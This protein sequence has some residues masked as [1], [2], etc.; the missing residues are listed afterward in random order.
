MLN[1]EPVNGY[2]GGDMVCGIGA[3]VVEILRIKKSALRFGRRFF[4][5]VFTDNEIKYCQSKKRGY[6]H[7]AARFAAKEAVLKA[8][9][10]GWPMI[11]LKHVEVVNDPSTGSPEIRLYGKAKYLAA[12]LQAHT[13][14]ISL[15]HSE[16]FATAFAVATKKVGY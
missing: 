13:I 15:S 7:L 10:V 12:S 6:E 3:D 9:G 2:L 14:F 1:Q 16:H 11:P 5:R 4:E 8:L